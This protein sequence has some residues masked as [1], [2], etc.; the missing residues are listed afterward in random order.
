MKKLAIS[1][2]LLVGLAAWGQELLLYKD[3][4]TLQYDAPATLPNLLPGE[5]LVYKVYLW[6][7]AQGTPPAGTTTGWTY[8]ASTLT[9]SQ[10]IVIPPDPRLAYAVGVQL[11]LIRADGIEAPGYF[12]MTTNPADVAPAPA[13]PGV[14]F[15]YAPAGLPT[16]GGARNLRDSGT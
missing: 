8:Y 3:A 14:P 16:L 9:L 12:A 5:S 7:L 13:Y 6:D 15:G 10:Y 11:V 1:L 2:L 4:F